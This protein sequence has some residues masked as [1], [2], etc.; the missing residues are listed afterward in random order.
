MVTQNAVYIQYTLSKFR[1]TAK[2]FVKQIK[3]IPRILQTLRHGMYFYLAWR[4]FFEAINFL[5]NA[6]ITKTWL[7]EAYHN[8]FL[9]EI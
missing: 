1:S 4:N 5:Y 8:P 9:G 2:L 6:R 7:F 3:A